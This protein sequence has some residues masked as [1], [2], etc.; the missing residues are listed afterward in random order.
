MDPATPTIT[1]SVTG[2]TTVTN[3]NGNEQTSG[4]PVFDNTYTV[5]PRTA[6]LTHLMTQKRK[7]YKYYSWFYR[8][9]L[10]NVVGKQLWKEKRSSVL[11]TVMAS[12][13]DEAMALLLLENS[14]DYWIHLLNNPQSKVKRGGGVVQVDEVE[15]SQ[16]SAADG[17]P[18]SGET[19]QNSNKNILVGKK[20]TIS[21]DGN[22]TQKGWSE[23][24]LRRM[25]E[26][27]VEVRLDRQQDKNRFD[28]NY[29]QSMTDERWGV[30]L[31]RSDVAMLRTEIMEMDGWSD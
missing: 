5:E 15:P 21:G 18:A 17:S 6:E 28:D 29:N 9:V 26:L 24:G 10:P 31:P 25:N 11:G 2:T 20:Y 12:V 16:E 30:K 22:K 23:E 4:T 8:V 1:E 7:D 19:M 14:W 13:S 27:M 3:R